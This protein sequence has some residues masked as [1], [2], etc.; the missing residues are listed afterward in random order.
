MK[1]KEIIIV[2]G[3]HDV[4]KIK[5]C[6]DADV[7]VSNGTHCSKEFLSQ[8]QMWNQTRGII[9]FTDPDGPGEYIRRQII[10]AVGTCK[11]ATLTTKQAKSK[12]HVG[13]EHATCEMIIEALSHAATYDIEKES[14]SWADFVDGEFVGLPQSQARRARLSELFYFPVSNAKTTFKYLNMLGIT[15]EDIRKGGLE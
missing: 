8:C 7:I 4:S 2:E 14:L 10:D 12:E 13:V 1:I 11:H 3:K 6:V 15:M 5:S 9:V